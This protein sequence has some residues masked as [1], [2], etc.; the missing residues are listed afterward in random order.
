MCAMAH[1]LSGLALYVL[2]LMEGY[3]Q[4]IEGIESV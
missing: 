3:K 1:T 2:L 4:R